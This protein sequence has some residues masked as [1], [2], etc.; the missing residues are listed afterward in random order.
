MMAPPDRWRAWTAPAKI[1]LFLEV[2][3]KRDD[4]YHEVETLMAP[5]AIWDTL[6]FSP[7]QEGTIELACRWAAPGGAKRFASADSHLD[8][9]HDSC[10]GALSSLLG[11]LPPEKDNLAYRAVAL[12]KKRS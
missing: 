6:F 2:L 12:L 9:H 3:G 8:A 5:I 7:R 4:G 1:N 10:A 11:D